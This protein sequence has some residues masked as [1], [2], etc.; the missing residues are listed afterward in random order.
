MHEKS[1]HG[2]AAQLNSICL[3]SNLFLIG[4]TCY[5]TQKITLYVR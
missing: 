4:E 3:G 5:H 1:L 2:E